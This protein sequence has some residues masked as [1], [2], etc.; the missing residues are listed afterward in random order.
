MDMGRE[1]DHNL[2]KVS[3]FYYWEF[4]WSSKLDSEFW[5]LT[6]L[7]LVNPYNEMG[8]MFELN[9]QKV[10]SAEPFIPS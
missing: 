5:R 1:G 8:K 6:R 9:N 7:Y 10:W 3:T 4:E 2:I